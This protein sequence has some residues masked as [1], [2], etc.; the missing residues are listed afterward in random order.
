MGR[1]A[2][3]KPKK[4]DPP[5]RARQWWA[6][7]KKG[8]PAALAVI[9]TI[10]II[11]NIYQATRETSFRSEFGPVQIE[12]TKL[13]S[14]NYRREQQYRQQID[15]LQIENARLNNAS[16]AAAARPNL[17]QQHILISG[18]EFQ[19]LSRH[20]WR[21][22]ILAG[23]T[24]G[25]VETPLGNEFAAA[26]NAAD[27]YRLAELHGTFLQVLN[28]GSV[29]AVN[30]RLQLTGGRSVN[31]GTL[32][33]NSA[34]YVLIAYERERPWRERRIAAPRRLFFQYAAG[35]AFASGSHPYIAPGNRSWVPSLSEARGMGSAIHGGTKTHLLPADEA[36]Q[37]TEA[38]EVLANEQ[39]AD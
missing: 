30:V 11:I 18:S 8:G 2:A 23:E 9:T 25:F 33:P 13:S 19:R 4:G 35:D 10:S 28:S 16:L 20:N 39:A 36:D 14:E 12:N 24:S 7:V 38:N 32:S 17:L 27:Q 34:K 21:A 37:P 5:T 15:Q 6:T 3:A 31:I 29:Q 1:K 22:R 26:V